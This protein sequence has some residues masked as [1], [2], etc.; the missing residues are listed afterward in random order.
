MHVLRLDLRLQ[1]VIFKVRLVNVPARRKPGI[2]LV[3]KEHSQQY[4]F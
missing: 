1:L 4:D 3:V 2:F